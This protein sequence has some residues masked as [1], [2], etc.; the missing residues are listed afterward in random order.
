MDAQRWLRF[1]PSRPQLMLVM[2]LAVLAA[3][4]AGFVDLALTRS[5][6]LASLR[7]MQAQV[8]SQEAQ[9]DQIVAALAQAQQGQHIGP[10]AWEYYGLT[11]RGVGIILRAVES[12][13][14]P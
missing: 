14:D 1:L 2:A 6:T 13:P 5:A 7:Q 10:R 8:A 12:Q 4:A 11:G 9:H 3:F